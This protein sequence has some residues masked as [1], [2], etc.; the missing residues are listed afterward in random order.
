[1]LF[2][3]DMI[4][5]INQNDGLA[6]RFSPV[7]VQELELCMKSIQQLGEIEPARTVPERKAGVFQLENHIVKKVGGFSPRRA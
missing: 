3:F 7:L 2:P 1:M 4:Q 6:A 5:S